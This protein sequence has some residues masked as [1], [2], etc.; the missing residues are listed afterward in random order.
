MNDKK[1][2][3]DEMLEKIFEISNDDFRNPDV[4]LSSEAI[5]C[6]NLASSIFDMPYQTVQDNLTDLALNKAI[7]EKEDD[8]D[9]YG[10]IDQYG[11]DKNAWKH[12]KVAFLSLF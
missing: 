9:R 7:Q 1:C 6:I 4:E 5:T 8:D 3:Y 12:L 11:D 2:S 10:N